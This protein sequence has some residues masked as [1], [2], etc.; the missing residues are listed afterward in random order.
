MTRQPVEAWP[1]VVNAQ[2]EW[3]PPNF[4]DNFFFFFSIFLFVTIRTTHSAMPFAGF[5]KLPTKVEEASSWD[6]SHVNGRPYLALNIVRL[7]QFSRQA[8]WH[9]PS[10]IYY[11]APAENKSKF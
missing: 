9:S 4:E 6:I 2:F 8:R 3:W 11:Q 5:L 10:Q 1:N 7:D